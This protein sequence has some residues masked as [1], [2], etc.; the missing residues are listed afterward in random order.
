MVSIDQYWRVRLTWDE[1]Q[2]AAGVGV[3]RHTESLKMKL[4]DAHGLK[5]K[6]SLWDYHIQG[7]IAETA[8]A[9]ALDIHWQAEVN[10]FKQPD[11]GAFQVRSTDRPYGRLILHNNDADDEI[12]ILAIGKIQQWYICGWC[13]GSEGKLP[14]YWED[15]QG[16]RPAYFVRQ[17]ALR[18]MDELEY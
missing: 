6:D 1:L 5:K 12:F 13:Y 2:R 14:K 10:T 16:G 8:V 7:A 15:P 4:K 9:K 18:K 3:I 17:S 11:V